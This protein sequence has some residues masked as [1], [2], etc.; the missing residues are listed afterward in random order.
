MSVTLKLAVSGKKHQKNYHL[1]A[2]NTRSRR[3]G[4]PLETFGVFN[5]LVKPPFLKIDQNRYEFWI[6]N[7]AQPTEKVKKLAQSLSSSKKP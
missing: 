4:K 2:A 7:G 6:K 5:P 1:V 3:Q